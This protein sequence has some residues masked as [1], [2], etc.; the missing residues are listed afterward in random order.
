MYSRPNL[1][2]LLHSLLTACRRQFPVEVMYTPTPEEDYM[3]AAIVAVFQIHEEEQGGDI[4]V[5]LTGQEE[6]ESVQRLLTDRIRR[7]PEGSPELI[8]RAHRSQLPYTK[9]YIYIRV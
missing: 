9:P 4:L 8:I 2:S 5:F 6:I 1:P 3:D 7:L